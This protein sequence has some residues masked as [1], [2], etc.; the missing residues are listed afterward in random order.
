[1]AE[2]YL[3]SKL[4]NYLLIKISFCVVMK[5]SFL[6][7][8]VY[9]IQQY[10]IEYELSL[11]FFTFSNLKKDNII[12]AIQLNKTVDISSILNNFMFVIILK[13]LH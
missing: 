5:Y 7:K 9:F 1:M 10:K 3:V 12:H 2:Q 4:Y 8:K 11:D 13:A 6:S